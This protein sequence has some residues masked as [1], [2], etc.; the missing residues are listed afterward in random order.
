MKKVLTILLISAILTGCGHLS[1]DKPYVA[2]ET[3]TVNQNAEKTAETTASDAIDTT[4]AVTVTSEVTAEISSQSVTEKTAERVT[5]A[6]VNADVQP[7]KDNKQAQSSQDNR[8]SE[9][10]KSESKTTTKAQ[11]SPQKVTTAP[12]VK[13][14]KTTT[15]V[16]TSPPAVTTAS[17]VVTQPPK[18]TE[19]PRQ[20]EPPAPK[21]QVLDYDSLNDQMQTFIDGY[22]I[23]YDWLYEKGK[24]L[25]HDGTD[26]GKAVA[27]CNAAESLGGV[28]CINYAI[29]AYFMAQGAGLECYIARSSDYDWYGHVANIIRLD[30]KWYYMEP[31]GDVVGSPTSCP[32][33]GIPYPNG[34]DIVTDIYDN[35]KDV[36]VESDWYK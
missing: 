29:N 1:E 2:E 13:E 28:N 35:R 34:L 32:S 3:T 21:Q 11:T 10:K 27:V 18:Q 26:Y 7:K 24:A 22:D 16:R 17:P 9:V 6:V 33:G 30:G 20:T 8:A 15:T 36:T 31:M 5:T 12:A 14:N 23:D 4:S 19:P 25:S